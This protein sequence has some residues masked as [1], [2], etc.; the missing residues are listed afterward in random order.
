MPQVL[1]RFMAINKPA[2]LKKSRRIAIIWCVISLVAAVAIGLN[3]RALYAAE[4]LTRGQ[5]ENI[6]IIM[7][8]GLLPTFLA[9]I[10]MSGILAATMSSSDSYLLIASSA[11]SRDIYKGIFK[12]D[13]TDNQVMVASRITLLLVSLFGIIIALDENSVIFKVVSFAWAGFGATFGP[14]I[15]FSLFWKRTTR[16]GAIAGM[17]TGGSMVF[18]WNMLISRLGGVFAIYE[19]L[20]AFVLSCIAIVVV[21]LLTK[22]ADQAVLDDFE[23]AK[24]YEC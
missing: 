19:L 6:F 20:P 9:G 21:S 8:T 1:L 2:E 15:L 17:L 22:K 13:A 16:A 14:I 24:S 3:G 4:L 23:A 5:A 10:V 7:S 11:L 12:K 18:I